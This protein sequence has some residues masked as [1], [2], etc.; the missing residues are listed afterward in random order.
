MH[1][2]QFNKF[3]IKL[4]QEKREGLCLLRGSS[5][6]VEFYTNPPCPKLIQ[7]SL[8][9]SQGKEPRHQCI[10]LKTKSICLGNER[11]VCLFICNSPSLSS[12]FICWYQDYSHSPWSWHHKIPE[13]SIIFFFCFVVV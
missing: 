3:L 4:P 5:S 8:G 6:M 9:G 12:G 1:P 7:I 10:N 11:D 2:I 13:A